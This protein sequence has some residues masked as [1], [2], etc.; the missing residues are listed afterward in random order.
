MCRDEKL[1]FFSI[2][3]FVEVGVFKAEHIFD[4]VCFDLDGKGKVDMLQRA[5]PQHLE[6]PRRITSN[7]YESQHN[8]LVP[9]VCTIGT[10]PLFGAIVLIHR[11]STTVLDNKNHKML[12]IFK[13]NRASSDSED[14]SSSSNEER[15]IPPG[16]PYLTKVNGK[17]AWARKKTPKPINPVQ[18]LLGE[19]FGSRAVIVR[20]R[21]KSLERPVRKV[22]LGNGPMARP[23]QLSYSAPIPQQAFTA[24]MPPMAHYSHHPPQYPP[25]HPPQYLLQP[26]PQPGPQPSQPP[27]LYIPQQPPI[28]APLFVQRSPTEKEKE[29]LKLFD[30]HF[31]TTVKPRTTRVTSAS[32]EDSQ[33]KAKDKQQEKVNKKVAESG[34]EE[35]TTKV[36]IAI[37]RHVCGDCGRLRSRKY[38]HDH[39]LRP[40]EIPELAFCRKCQKD[41]SS[42]SE[43]SDAEEE[44]KVQKKTK[45]KKKKKSKKTKASSKLLI[46]T[47]KTVQSSDDDEESSDHPEAPTKAKP[48][49][50]KPQ[51]EKPSA[52]AKQAT[53]EDYIVVE[54]KVSSHE[55]QPRGRSQSQAPQEYD[56]QRRPLSPIVRQLSVSPSSL[57]S[58]ARSSR[59]DH[60]RNVPAPIEIREVFREPARRQSPH[61][62]YRYVEVIPDQDNFERKEPSYPRKVPIHFVDEVVFEKAT[63]PKHN[64]QSDKAHERASS[65][66][67]YIAEEP[68][69]IPRSYHARVQDFD[70]DSLSR[71]PP[72]SRHETFDVREESNRGPPSSMHDSFEVHEAANRG[73]PSREHSIEQLDAM[74]YMRSSEAR[75]R[76]KRERAPP[77]TPDFRPWDEPHIV[78]PASDDEVIVVTET[79]EYR[80]Q[81]QAQG[82]EERRRQEYIDRATWSPRN[83]NQVSAEDASR[84]YHEDWLGAELPLI[85]GKPY[86]PYQP[87]KP[88]KG[89]RRDRHPESELTESEAS[90]DYKESARDSLPRAPTP[91]SPPLYESEV[92]KWAGINHMDWGD[93]SADQ[94]DIVVHMPPVEIPGR[95]RSNSNTQPAFVREATDDGTERALIVSPR[96]LDERKLG[97]YH[98]YS[99]SNL[100][101]RQHRDRFNEFSASNIT[102]LERQA[103]VEAR[104][105]TFR[106]TPSSRSIHDDR[107][108]PEAHSQQS[109]V[110]YSR[111]RGR[112]EV[113]GDIS[114]G[115][116]WRMGNML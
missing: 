57:R 21:S 84:Y 61:I 34:T 52:N 82:E 95:Q 71:G 101:E 91:P 92:N 90:Y 14:S 42:T 23:Q 98:D 106:E 103:E 105:V 35:S 112:G 12:S 40:G 107:A 48:D 9:V 55:R 31:N 114:W 83:H 47:K 11:L 45:S 37:T 69:S 73:P 102:E 25:Q 27:R 5:L 32:S 72:S 24:S 54:E 65:Y 99:E 16:T 2:D 6:F 85:V 22:I 115:D 70:Q 7:D 78:Y 110:E 109:Q 89:Y 66:K 33:E 43:S 29:Q 67:D 97:A 50:P 81:K 36:K 63:S 19:A 86:Q 28:P 62:P 44:E 108:S 80:K 15:V 93:E 13:T 96:H 20:R 100:T 8:A 104:H 39:P 59:Q 60:P 94:Q 17:L 46:L 75:R 1:N 18:D 64:H 53:S 58:Y 38:H 51:P 88:K 56:T 74:N 116:M 30:A 113:G 10:N 41:A 4:E 3:M 79:Y 68:E 76:R 77:G 111:G 49:Q 26:I 87:A